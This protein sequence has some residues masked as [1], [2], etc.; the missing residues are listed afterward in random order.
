MPYNTEKRQATAV[1]LAIKRRKGSAAAKAFAHKH[2]A[3]LRAE[4]RT[5]TPRTRRG[6]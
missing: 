5:Y 4:R 2:S 3:D 6:A 1:L